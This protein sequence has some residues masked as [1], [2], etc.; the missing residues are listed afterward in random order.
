MPKQVKLALTIFLFT[1]LIGGVIG[2][3]ITLFSMGMV[4]S[5]LGF[6]AVVGGAVSFFG[7]GVIRKAKEQ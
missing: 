6:I 2:A 7:L 3:A 1:C 5:G 4:G